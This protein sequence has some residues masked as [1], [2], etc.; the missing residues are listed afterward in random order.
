M[1]SAASAKPMTGLLGYPDEGSVVRINHTT[2]A[3]IIRRNCGRR[4]IEPFI[5]GP[6]SG[7]SKT[8][9]RNARAFR[10]NPKQAARHRPVA[11]GG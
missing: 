8:I 9:H 3:G 11:A 6:N 1:V 2:E 5:S 4:L 10:V 7:S